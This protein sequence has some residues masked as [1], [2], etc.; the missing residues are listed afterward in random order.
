M[1]LSLCPSGTTNNQSSQH[2][3]VTLETCDLWDI[4]SDIWSDLLMSIL[5][6]ILMTIF[7]DNFWWQFFWTYFQLVTCDIW[8]TDYN[9]DN[10]ETGFMTIFVT[11]Q[12][13]VT[14]DSIRNS[15]DVYC[16]FTFIAS[17]CHFYR[18]GFPSIVGCEGSENSIH[19]IKLWT[20]LFGAW[21]RKSRWM[22][23]CRNIVTV[24][25]WKKK[26]CSKNLSGL[27]LGR[28]ESRTECGICENFNTN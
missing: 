6:T 11:W 17:L 28:D 1:T 3:R 14:L 13:I 12:L 2:Y 10:W 22:S 23:Q 7:D 24:V 21:L 25:I 5:M 19:Y 20:V 4:W 18:L 26:H 27:I 16:T 15:C 8:D 9:T